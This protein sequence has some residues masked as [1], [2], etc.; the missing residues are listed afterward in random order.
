M[1]R[2]SGKYGNKEG[3]LSIPYILIPLFLTKIVKGV[4]F[5]A[6]VTTDTMFHYWVEAVSAAGVS[7]PSA[8]LVVPLPSYEVKH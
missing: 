1:L 3:R 4:I 6:P 7:E 5:C 2:S 8:V